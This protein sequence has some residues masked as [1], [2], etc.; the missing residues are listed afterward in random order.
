ME[1]LG[2]LLS[3]VIFP[4][5]CTVLTAV[6][7]YLGVKAKQRLEKSEMEKTKKEVIEICVKATEQLFKEATSTE[8]FNECVKAATEMLASRGITIS[9][10]EIKMLIESCVAEF[11]DAFNRDST[12]TYLYS[13]EVEDMDINE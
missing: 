12:I 8:K 4:I 7:G 5:L 10:F 1:T 3:T 6:V 9:E 2:E 13:D 11:S